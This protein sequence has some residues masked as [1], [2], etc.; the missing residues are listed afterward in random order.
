MYLGKE[1]WLTLEWITSK[2]A[3]FFTGL[4][5]TTNT[6]IGWRVVEVAGSHKGAGYSCVNTKYSKMTPID[7]SAPHITEM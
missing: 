7:V 2:I 6:C 3:L 4:V 5:N 1:L